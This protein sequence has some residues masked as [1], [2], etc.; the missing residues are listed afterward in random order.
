MS[1]DPNRRLLTIAEAAD[2]VERPESTLRRWISEGRLAPAASMGKTSLFLESD[3]LKA[4]AD[5]RTSRARPVAF[6]WDNMGVRKPPRRGEP[7]G[8]TTD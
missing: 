1:W 7:S 2:S 6:P 4:E 5:A 3:V 8:G